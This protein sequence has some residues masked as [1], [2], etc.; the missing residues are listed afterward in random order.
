ME[1]NKVDYIECYRWVWNIDWYRQKN[2]VDGAK[3]GFITDKWEKKKRLQT[4]EPFISPLSHIYTTSTPNTKLAYLH[5]LAS[6]F[7]MKT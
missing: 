5:F 7:H 3:L 1:E 2:N 6:D 4:T